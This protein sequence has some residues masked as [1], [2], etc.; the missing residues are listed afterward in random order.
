MKKKLAQFGRRGFVGGILV[1]LGAVGGSLLRRFQSPSAIRKTKPTKLDSRFVYDVSEWETTDRSLLLYETETEFETGFTR[2]KRL[3]VH[4]DKVFVAGDRS[5]KIFDASGSLQSEIKLSRPPHCMHV[6][7]EKEL[8]VGLGNYFEVYDFAGERKLKA[9]RPEGE[10]TFLTAIAVY[11]DTVYLADAGM[12]EVLLCDRKTGVVKSRFGKK[13][14]EL[15]NPGIVI[16]S[17][18]FDLTISSVGEVCL[19]NTGRLRMETYSL[20]GRFKATWG[21]PGMAVDKFCGCCNPVYFTLTPHGDYITSEKGLARINVYG[22]DGS[23]KGAVAGPDMLV[24]D[25]ALAKQACNDCSVGAGF[26]VAMDD[27]GRV[28][29]LDPFRMVVRVFK[30]AEKQAPPAQV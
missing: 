5:V 3:A 9:P 27:Q 16:P 18:Y 10:N 13:D 20:D 26:D 4:G 29:A 25:K 6:T 30:P 14:E 7:P 23:F 17:P 22:P 19:A 1:A 11:E 12:R 21:E 8:F 15:K 2:S 24:E 28:L